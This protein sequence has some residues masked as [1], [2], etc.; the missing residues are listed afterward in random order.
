MSSKSFHIP[1]CGGAGPALLGVEFKDTYIL[2]LS[3][4][5]ALIAG[6]LWGSIAY[7]GVPAAGFYANRYYIEWRD[8]HLPG[9][10][11]ASLF[12]HGLAEY[13]SGFKSGKTEFVGDAHVINPGSLRLLE[14]CASTGE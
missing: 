2:I 1:K 3:I 14:Q 10:F 12:A 5:A 8:K 11:R 4:F 9:F 6:K 13:S 7:L